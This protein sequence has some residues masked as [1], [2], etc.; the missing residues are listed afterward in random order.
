MYNNNTTKAPW[1]KYILFMVATMLFTTAYNKNSRF[2]FINNKT[3][4]SFRFT[5]VQNLIVIPVKV[6]DMDLNL[7]LD[8]GMRSIVL[9]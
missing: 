8:T 1:K 3:E 9:F 2:K 7:I 5:M 6:N 4:T